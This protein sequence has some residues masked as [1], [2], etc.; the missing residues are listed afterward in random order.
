M[1]KLTGRDFTEAGEPFDLFDSWLTEARRSEVNDPE[2]MALATVDANGLPDVRMVLL[3]EAKPKG[4]VFYSNAESAKGR[5]LQANPKAAGV[6]HWKSLRRQVRFRGAVERVSDAEADA[7]FASR[8]LQSRIGAWAS[9]QS[10][11]L[12][13]RFALETA[14]AK[15]AA[16]FAFG[17][18]PRPPYWVGYRVAPVY[19]EFWSDGA[20][21][22]HDRIVFERATPDAPWRKERLYP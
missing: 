10:R 9:Q 5:E 14:V 13:S 21:R 18:I 20:F 1:N 16:K 11:P 17:E 22:L 19:I 7:Y 3:K 6:L 15:Y 2:A 8:A 4:F 12:E